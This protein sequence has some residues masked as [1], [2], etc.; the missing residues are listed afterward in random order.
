MNKDF[1]SKQSSKL[2]IIV[3]FLVGLLV[4]VTGSFFIFNSSRN[5]E[6]E[7]ANKKTQSSGRPDREISNDQIE[8]ISPANLSST[9]EK[10]VLVDTTTEKEFNQLKNLVSKSAKVAPE[11]TLEII[12]QITDPRKQRDALVRLF[13]YWIASDQGMAMS[14]LKSISNLSLQRHLFREAAKSLAYST[15]KTAVQLLESEEG[16]GNSGIWGQA[17][18]TWMKYD[19]DAA[20]KKMLSIQNLSNRHHA[21]QA[22]AQQMASTDIHAAIEWVDTL[23]DNDQKTALNKILYEGANSSPMIVAEYIDGLAEGEFKLEITGRV[24]KEWAEFDPE[25]AIKWSDSLD[26]KLRDQALSHIASEVLELDSDRAEQIT[27]KISSAEG[28]RSLMEQIGRLQMT[29]NFDEAVRWMEEL[30]EE[31]RASAWRGAAK[32]WVALDPASA[33]QY[34]MNIED[35]KIQEQLVDALSYSWPRID[36]QAAANWAQSLSGK[37]QSEALY[38]IVDTWARDSPQDAAFFVQSSLEGELQEKMTRRV[39]DRLMK[40]NVDQAAEWVMTLD[41]GETKK[42]AYRDLAQYWLKRD[43]MK[44]SEWIAHLPNSPERDSAVSA[45]INNIER[46]DPE[47]AIIWAETLSDPKAQL[48]IHNRILKQISDQ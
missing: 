40:N 15:P 46:D 41:Q 34:A 31:D 45:L 20:L 43:S 38:R 33:S 21:L 36:P 12:L 16:F 25:E 14:A 29:A 47:T 7:L 6:R 19:P 5:N 23:K 35:P 39:A 24:A 26:N 8:T 28:R 30:P 22:I 3:V 4:G 13:N 11:K 17:F 48:S 37:S 42:D 1:F 9:L 27:R 2:F 32:E 44:A 10:L 18:S